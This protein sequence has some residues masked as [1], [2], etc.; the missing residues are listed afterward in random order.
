MY[1]T[2]SLT[3]LLKDETSNK[4]KIKNFQNTIDIEKKLRKLLRQHTLKNRGKLI[5]SRANSK[6]Y[7]YLEQ[8][9]YEQI[10]SRAHTKNLY[11]LEKEKHTVK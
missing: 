11:M 8:K 6:K 3:T 4:N 7:I 9:V 1:S 10:K 2:C 5:K